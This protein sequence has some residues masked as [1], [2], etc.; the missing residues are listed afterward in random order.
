MIPIQWRKAYKPITQVLDYCP[1]VVTSTIMFKKFF[2][3]K[4]KGCKDDSNCAHGVKISAETLFNSSLFHKDTLETT[5]MH[6]YTT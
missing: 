3:T 4:T 1:E 2:L 5:H 6:T